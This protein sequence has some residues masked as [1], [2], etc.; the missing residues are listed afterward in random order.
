MTENRGQKADIGIRPPG[1]RGGAYAPAGSGKAEFGMIK[2][3]AG[4][5]G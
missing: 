1:H 4:G 2:H 3:R 5:M